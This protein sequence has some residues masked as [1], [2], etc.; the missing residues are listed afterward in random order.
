MKQNPLRENPPRDNTSCNNSP[1]NNLSR[2]DFS[3][4]N[5]SCNDFSCDKDFQK[6]DFQM[7]GFK[8]QDFLDSYFYKPNVFQKFLAFA[9][10]PIS[11]VYLCVA[12]CKRKFWTIVGSK[13]LFAKYAMPKHFG[14]P[15]ISVGNIIAGGSGKTPFIIYLAR[16]LLSKYKVK[17][18]IISRGYGRSSKGLVWVAQDGQICASVQEAGDEPFLIAK[19]LLAKQHLQQDTNKQT[20]NISQNISLIVC[21]NREKAI[22]EAIKN[23]VKIILLDDAFRFC[24]DKFDI[25]LRPSKEPHFGFCLPSGLYRES[26]RVYDTYT[27]KNQNNISSNITQKNHLQKNLA[28]ENHPLGTILKEGVDFVRKVRVQNPSPKMLLLT[29]IAN[30]S[31]LESFLQ[32]YSQNILGKITLKDHATFEKEACERWLKSSGATSILTTQKDE[33]KLESFGLPLSVMQLDLEV[34]NKAL[35][36]IINYIDTNLDLGTI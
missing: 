25:I 18:C 13:G 6:Q 2:N 16:F 30:P 9:L 29:A 17:I 7:Q 20:Q 1:N 26:I 11:F 31:R 3:H 32:E 14:V 34:K 28:Q 10:L 12:T 21:E 24:F 33:V 15:I 36:P 35:E 8:K 23:Q 5:S 22:K 19:S 27:R 4:N